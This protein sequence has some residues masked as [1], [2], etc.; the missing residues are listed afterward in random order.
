M[1]EANIG[2]FNILQTV[3]IFSLGYCGWRRPRIPLKNSKGLKQHHL[4]VLLDKVGISRLMVLCPMLE[5]RL[6]EAGRRPS[7]KTENH[8]LPDAA[9][10]LHRDMKVEVGTLRKLLTDQNHWQRLTSL[11]QLPE[12]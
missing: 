5:E 9:Q 12:A 7:L 8:S 1:G 10:K 3:G 11:R 4:E 2:K 6:L